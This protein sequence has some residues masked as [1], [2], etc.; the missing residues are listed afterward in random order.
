MY[1]L[2][3]KLLFRL[4]AETAHDLVTRQMVRAQ[5]ITPLL[6]VVR[7]AMARQA[8]SRTLWGL[9]F[10]NPLGIAAGFDKNAELVPMLVALGFG[11]IEVGTVTLRPQAGNPRPR[12]FRYP[13][14][15]ALVNR[16]GFNNEG[17][18]AVAE[19]M[20]RYW[21]SVSSEA[22]RAHPPV[23]VNI[24]KNKEVSLE[25]AAENYVAAYEIL[26]PLADAVVVNVSSPNT[27]SL[28]DLQRPEQLAQ[29]LSALREARSRARFE[30]PAG[31]HP[32][33]VK[34]APDL[35]RAQLAEVCDV[36]VRM[37]DGLTATN[38]TIDKARLEMD[39]V[40]AG[41]ISG[42]PLFE[43]STAILRE[44]RRLV[45]SEYPLIG[46]GGVMGSREA[47]AKLEAGANLV[48]GY[49]GLIYRGPAFARD[50]VRGLSVGG[51]R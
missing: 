47:M 5:G 29:I 41:G 3:K 33:I 36:A 16:L 20:R 51:V 19:R 9:Q 37:A 50:V 17:A 28:R 35:D 25:A 46:V 2:A 7:R 44:A 27:P 13:G 38:T 10:E 32:I 23:F 22:F 8:M 43:L 48:Q 4:D 14:R 34:I 45:G 30:R 18:T 42:Y 21:H 15:E 24:G 39:F 49:T 6:S 12:M 11:F 26:A 40:E 31:T 1:E